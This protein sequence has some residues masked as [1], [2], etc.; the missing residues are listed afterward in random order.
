MPNTNHNE[1]EQTNIPW[2]SGLHWTKQMKKTINK[3]KPTAKYNWMRFVLRLCELKLRIG[4]TF[5]DLKPF[6]IVFC[7]STSGWIISC[8]VP[9]DSCA[10][11][12][13]WRLIGVLIQYLNTYSEPCFL[14]QLI[15]QHIYHCHWLTLFISIVHLLLYFIEI[16]FLSKYF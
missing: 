15:Y 13:A 9:S 7:I 16:V 2:S 5:Y 6:S 14:T 12:A 8:S 3:K 4:S 1:Q 11:Q 10:V